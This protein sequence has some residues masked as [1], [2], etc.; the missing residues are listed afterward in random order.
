MGQVGAKG[1]GVDAD[2]D[3][4]AVVFDEACGKTL[5][6]DPFD[7][8]VAVEAGDHGVANAKAFNRDF[9]GRRGDAGATKITY[10]NS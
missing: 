3:L 10:W 2:R 7:A 1:A 8:A 4:V 9:P 5:L 6:A